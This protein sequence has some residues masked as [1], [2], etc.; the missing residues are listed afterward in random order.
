MCK[1]LSCCVREGKL[2]FGVKPLHF[3]RGEVG[4]GV[5]AL[6]PVSLQDLFTVLDAW[7]E[8]ERSGGV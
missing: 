5:A 4:C 2:R 1:R 3:P 8:N 6:L 7:K